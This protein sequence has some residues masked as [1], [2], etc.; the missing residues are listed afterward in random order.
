MCVCVIDIKTRGW[1]PDTLTLSTFPC[2]LCICNLVNFFR[3]NV[4]TRVC[5]ANGSQLRAGVCRPC[6]TIEMTA[7][8]VHFKRLGSRVFHDS[9]NQYVFVFSKHCTCRKTNAIYT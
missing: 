1:G 7:T 3:I 4:W 6:D 2:P 8:I 9:C 5:T